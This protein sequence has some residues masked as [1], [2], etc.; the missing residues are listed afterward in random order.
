MSIPIGCYGISVREEKRKAAKQPV[1]IHY[2][3]LCARTRERERDRE[4]SN[5]HTVSAYGLL[6]KMLS[7]VTFI[8]VEA[9]FVTSFCFEESWYFSSCS[10]SMVP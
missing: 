5:T 9:F 6:K 3:D 8:T 1:H 7:S 10:Y 4:R 2:R